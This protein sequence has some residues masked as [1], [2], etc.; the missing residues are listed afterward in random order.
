M[1]AVIESVL[2][3]E[4][5]V[6]GDVDGER[7]AVERFEDLRA[8][9]AARELNRLVYE[10]TRRAP[11]DRDF[12]FCGQIRRASISTMSNVAEGFER[13]RPKEFHQFLSIAKSSCGE[14]RSLLYAAMDA[15]YCQEDEFELLSDHTMEASRLIN[16]LRASIERRLSA[17]KKRSGS[18]I[19]VPKHSAPST[20]HNLGAEVHRG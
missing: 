3:A 10:L 20:Q 13:A 9:Q 14:V 6:L 15:N 12:A 2:S 4:C 17:N 11:V 16:A 18:C 8:W 5:W 7:M 19:R 1:G